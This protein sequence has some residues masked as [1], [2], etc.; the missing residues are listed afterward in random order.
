MAAH[1]DSTA[2]PVGADAGLGHQDT[3]G[4]G[5]RSPTSAPP[6]SALPGSC[7]G[8]RIPHTTSPP[9]EPAPPPE[10]HSKRLTPHKAPDSPA[11][12]RQP[13]EGRSTRMP[14]EATRHVEPCPLLRHPWT[15]S[16]SGAHGTPDTGPKGALP[17]FPGAR[18]AFGTP[19]LIGRVPR[20]A[21]SARDRPRQGA[22]CS[23]QRQASGS[24]APDI[25]TLAYRRRHTPALSCSEGPARVQHSEPLGHLAAERRQQ[26]L[27]QG[28]G[29]NWA[30]TRGGGPIGLATS[31][32]G[33]RGFQRPH[34]SWP[35]GFAYPDAGWESACTASNC[36]GDASPCGATWPDTWRHPTGGRRA[37]GAPR[38]RPCPAL[39]F[40]Q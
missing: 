17:G 38:P 12:A 23:H 4:L 18:S 10:Q 21:L 14:T 35:G 19:E 25:G 13:S 30:M 16:S 39:P 32:Q 2:V 6:A 33:A 15:P 3:R 7:H 26:A 29:A 36:L 34:R 1:N 8:H 22:R 37:H 28:R 40:R 5:A 9:C 11:S 20:H 24:S 31:A 27:Q